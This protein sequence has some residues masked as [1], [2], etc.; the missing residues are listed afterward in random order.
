[1]T[2]AVLEVSD[3]KL[4]VNA[5][6]VWRTILH[7]VKLSVGSGEA[8]A[9]VGE[10]GSGKSLTARS[11]V[12][13]P[14]AGARLTG[15]ILFNGESVLGFKG[16]RLHQYRSHDVAMIY[17]DPAMHVNPLQTVGSYLTEGLRVNDGL[18]KKTAF[19][20]GESLLASVG[21]DDTARRMQQYPFEFSGGMLQR[22][23]V[24][25]ALSSEPRLLVADEPTTALDVTNQAEIMSILASL[26]TNR[27]LAMLFITHDLELAAATCNR[28]AVMYAGRVVEIQGAMALRANPLHPYAA[29][30]LNC[31]PSITQ[32]PRRLPVI[33]GTAPTIFEEVEG[34]PYA[35]RCPR[36]QEKCEEMPPLRSAP[37]GGMVAC[38]FPLNDRPEKVEVADVERA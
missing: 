28:I 21:I 7:G 31:R 26:R 34:C 12:R 18:S 13:M 20:I 6:G 23:A 32:R 37:G 17:Q 29:A 25:A 16:K 10:S 1:M 11:I 35:A 4:A 9:L 27:A 3:L 30:L 15:E 24:A 14:P 8:V 19:E 5:Y 22:V 38:W 2:E 33:E 36:A